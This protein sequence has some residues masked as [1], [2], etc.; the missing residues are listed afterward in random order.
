M[1]DPDVIE[2]VISL[3]EKHG[4]DCWWSLPISELMP[5]GPRRDEAENGLWERGMDTLDVWFDSGCSW[6]AVLGTRGDLAPLSK[7][8][9]QADVYLEGSDQHRG[10]FQSSLLTAVA[11]QRGATQGER[12]DADDLTAKA[13]INAPFRRLVTHGFVLDE[14]GRKMSKSLGN[15][16]EPS[17][18]INGGTSGGAGILGEGADAGGREKKKQKKKKT[19]TTRWAPQGVDVLR[20]WTASSDY[21]RDIMIGKNI[22]E[23]S[24]GGLRK[25]RN[26]ARFILGNLHDFD[27]DSNGI[28]YDDLR[29]IDR[30][31]IHRTAIMLQNAQK[32]YGELNFRAV[33]DH[34][35]HFIANDLSSLYFEV[36]KDP[37]YV[38]SHNSHA[39]R[40]IQTTLHAILSAILAV[41]SPIV[42]YTAEDIFQY[43]A[44]AQGRAS[45]SG[46]A[47]G[48][49]GHGTIFEVD[50]GSIFGVLRWL[51][52]DLRSQKNTSSTANDHLQWD[53]MDGLS[54]K[55]C[56]DFEL[57][58]AWEPIGKLRTDANR[59]LENARRNKEIGSSLD[60]ELKLC[61]DWSSDPALKESLEVFGSLKE[62]FVVSGVEFVDTSRSEQK[63]ESSVFG[64]PIETNIFGDDVNTPIKIEAAVPRGTKCSRCWQH[65]VS[66]TVSAELEDF[67]D[68]PQEP[69]CKSCV[70][71]ILDDR[72]PE[73]RV[74][75]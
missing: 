51:D 7:K 3:V 65:C 35:Q 37:L 22:V 67:A 54:M 12:V 71:H 56:I 53:V 24:S 13:T 30:L 20:L 42:P 72:Y 18:V 34:L 5:E 9:N 6:A 52:D 50:G 66:T 21:T 55:K 73:T 17:V 28:A 40:S 69:I 2:H 33:I 75:L 39:R 1:T 23:T 62:L 32:G 61:A 48:G 4:S 16:I 41:A 11:V 57:E 10:W 47:D 46:E 26:T 43:Y 45:V 36:C 14:Q 64:E 15:I 58:G 63:V 25:L 27:L 38:S 60:A 70:Q 49:A 59:V 31:L 19:K 74:K 29:P 44:L 68:I 8:F